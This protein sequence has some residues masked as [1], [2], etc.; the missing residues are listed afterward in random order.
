[1]SRSPTPRPRGWT[2]WRVVADHL[3]RFAFREELVFDWK[4]DG[5]GQATG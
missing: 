5:A 1:M 4:R 2:G 3:R